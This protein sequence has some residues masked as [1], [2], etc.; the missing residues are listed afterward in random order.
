MGP[1]GGDL[2]PTLADLS[3]QTQTALQPRPPMAQPSPELGWDPQQPFA[4]PTAGAAPTGDVGGGYGPMGVPEGPPTAGAAPTGDVGGGIQGAPP[5]EAEQPFP[6]GRADVAGTPELPGGAFGG[7]SPTQQPTQRF[8][9]TT[10]ETVQAPSPPKV[11]TGPAQ[12][13]PGT[14]ASTGPVSSRGQPSP[15]QT[16]VNPLKFMGDIFNLLRGNPFPLMSDLSGLAGQ[17]MGLPPGTPGSAT[18]GAPGAPGTATPTGPAAA[19]AGTQDTSKLPGAPNGPDPKPDDELGQRRKQWYAQNPNAGTFPEDSNV[20]QGP[21]KEG[22]TLAGGEDLSAKTKASG[23]T[24]NFF[25]NG[26]AA[27]AGISDRPGQNIT[28]ITDNYGHTVKVNAHAAP[29]FKDFLNDL[30][31][32][33]YKVND[34]QGFVNRNKNLPG[35]QQGG[36]S[37]HAFG[38]AIDINPKQNS[39]G[40]G[41]GNMPANI[42]EI[43]ARHGLTW[44]GRAEWGRYN[45]PMHFEWTGVT[46]APGAQAAQAAQAAG[47]TTAAATGNGNLSGNLVNRVQQFE[48]YSARAYPDGSQ[49]SIGYGTRATS[50]NEVI[51]QATAQQ[52]LNSELGQ[53]QASVDRFAPGL[54]QNVRDGLTS[55]DYNTGSGWQRGP[56]G[57]AIRSGDY[58]RAAQ[59]IQQYHISQPGHVSRRA[60]EAQQVMGQ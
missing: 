59:L 7:G 45:D 51:D 30:Q 23:V 2:S 15:F 22:G 36:P 27:Q 13:A 17:A 8:D 18:P 46:G 37:E 41:R 47:N 49:Y 5:A 4:A 44:G 21:T 12:A 43:A 6:P 40:T 14:T 26:K 34:V 32:N 25:S 9:P 53:S 29:Y 33:G 52:R 48:G 11:P 19:P 58:Q 31:A 57:Q 20:P 60:W 54:P 16:G 3:R 50:P 55:L 35:G 38:N 28:S 39:Q 1:A 24:G 56:I 10:G 42:E